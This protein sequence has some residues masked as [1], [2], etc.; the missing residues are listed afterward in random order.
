M[1]RIGV[2]D[3]LER[4][5]KASV[6]TLNKRKVDNVTLIEAIDEAT[7]WPE[8][9]AELI[10][11]VPN[12][13]LDALIVR[14]PFLVCAIATEIG[15]RFEGIGT[16]YWGK[17]SDALGLPITMAQRVKIGEVFEVL[18]SK[19]KI[20]RPS[21]SA[22][23]AH[24]SIISWPI[25]NA[26]LPV[27][28][29]GPITRLMARAPVTALPSPGRAA[30]FAS[31]RAWAS[32][33]EGARLVDW[34]RFEAP[35][36]RVL[37][38]LLTENRQ[39]LLSDASFSRLRDVIAAEPETFFATRAARLRVRTAKP[40]VSDEQTL[41]R[42][43]LAHDASG[44]RLFVSWPALPPALF[45]EARVTARS[46]A[47]RPRLWGVG[48]FLHPNTA[49]SA[50]P[51]ELALQ[52]VP[53]DDETA[54]PGVAEV[55]GVGSDAA[56]ALASRSIDWRA[57]LLFD[58]NSDRTQAEQCF[59]VPSGQTGIVWVATRAGG[60]TLEE[61]RRLGCT[62]GY[63]VF[64]AN[65]A[66][67]GDRTVLL[68]EGL[69]STQSRLLLARHP[70]DAIGA[71]QGVVRPD[72]PFL[73]Y[74]AEGGT[75]KDAKPQ[76]LETGA[77]LA[78]IS[79][80]AGRPGLRAEAAALPESRVVD[81]F[82]FERDAVFEALTERRLQLRVESRLPLT[83]VAV[84]VE[85]EIDGRLVARGHDRLMALPMTVP[86]SSSLLAPLYDDRARTTLLEV[87]RG[88]LSIAIGR[89]VTLQI[90]I[91]RPAALVQWDGSTP[92][93]TGAN[94]DT[95][96]VTATAQ[97]PHRFVPTAA[98]Q[99]PSR[100]ATAFG[101]ILTDGR[102]IDPIQLFT[103]TTFGLG[104]LATQFGDD[105]GSRRM[106]DHGRGVGDIARARVAWA[107]G[108][109]RSLP[110]IVAKSR[111]VRQFEEPLVV[112]LCGRAW[113]LAEQAT[114]SNPSDPHIALWKVALERGLATV[115]EGV[116]AS[117]QD[118]FARAFR[119]HAK[120]LDPDWPLANSVPVDGGM[121]DA[122]NAAFTEVVL[123]FH[124]QGALLDVDEEDCDFGSVA[125]EW[126]GACA[127]ALLL[128]RR[129]PLTKLLVPSEGGRQL[130]RRFYSD[131]S[132]AE[133]AEDLSAWTKNWA[134]SRGK[135]SPEAAAG[136]LLLWLSPAACDDVDAAVRI[137]S[138]DPFVS[139][140]TRYA[141]LRFVAETEEANA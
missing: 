110:A 52:A 108:L 95:Q 84:T 140:A 74:N 122:L 5:L 13:D 3:G 4:Q 82:L 114:R 37:T 138:V 88:M 119:H 48:P 115:P 98:V 124:A 22:F 78:A 118:G 76:C 7:V 71:L 103:S 73:L 125:E 69:L 58:P 94:L 59:D 50:G 15:F 99:A 16:E 72:R 80:L 106:F 36:A 34:L 11:F 30:N 57:I 9:F 26:L 100:G 32:A 135:L 128:I 21:E 83:D 46:A 134:M 86:G 43:T 44:T 18:A 132:V 129:L 54:Y 113:S 65:L 116:T 141:A 104:D 41:G 130:S 136:A 62:C 17:L 123:D 27:D 64:E 53:A 92:K 2:I 61:L 91:E 79:G 14:A 60:A 10:P 51:F 6:V 28:L 139:R 56:A 68:R 20:S 87:G 39:F 19:Y 8:P 131:L 101:L 90:H 121:D 38:A 42:L 63:A 35:T 47:W 23:S 40:T 33:A 49:L 67:A 12:A 66:D 97:H 70:L 127:D 109:C 45:D 81:L 107:R 93:L 111:I 105:I 24:F 112:D 89:S 1:L 137:L 117:E 55:F 77:R 31:L 25:A 102:I 29:V 96:L 120:R 85:L 133:L 75:D 126:E